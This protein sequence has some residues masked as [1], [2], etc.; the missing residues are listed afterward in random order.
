MSTLPL[1][2]LPLPGFGDPWQIQA[3][4][5]IGD[6]FGN[7]GEIAGDVFGF[8]DDQEQPDLMQIV[9]G[10]FQRSGLILVGVVIVLVALWSVFNSGSAKAAS[11]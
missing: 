1:P 8:G 10:F 4:P 7:A 6:L 5:G 11:S 9:A 2:P 3:I